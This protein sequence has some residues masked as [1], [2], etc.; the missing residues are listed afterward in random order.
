M[1]KEWS[2]CDVSGVG[3]WAVRACVYACVYAHVCVHVCACGECTH[4]QYGGFSDVVKSLSTPTI[5]NEG[6]HVVE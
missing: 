6:I 4:D 1:R 3:G 2:P 5:S